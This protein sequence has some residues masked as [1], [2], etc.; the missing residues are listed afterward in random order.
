MHERLGDPAGKIRG[1]TVDLG[2][3]LAREGSA[4]VSSP[5]AVGVDDDLSAGE[6]GITLWS[7]ND[8][9]A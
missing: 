3:V 2:V 5:T 7:T 9:E 8:E 6:A 1:G 4:S